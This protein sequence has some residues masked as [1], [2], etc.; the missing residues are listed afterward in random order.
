[1]YDDV[2]AYFEPLSIEDKA[3][4]V[5]ARGRCFRKEDIGKFVIV[6]NSRRNKKVMPTMYLVDRNKTQRMWW[7]PSS[8]YAMVF[9]KQSAAEY[10][11]KKYRYNKARVMKI[12]SSMADKEWFDR[13]YD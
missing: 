9:E 1:M 3:D 11:A 2:E 13:M 7:S 10:Q 8:I 6:Q 5:S 4:Y 12:S